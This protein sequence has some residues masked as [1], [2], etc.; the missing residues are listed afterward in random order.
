[1]AVKINLKRAEK[2]ILPDGDYLVTV[3]DCKEGESRSGNPKINVQMVVD[4]DA[5]PDFAGVKLYLD[6]S[7]QESAW[8]R[9]VELYE[10]AKG[11]PVPENEDGDFSFDPEDLIGDT[12]MAIVEIDESF[13]G[14]PR[15]K[16]VSVYNQEAVEEV[17]E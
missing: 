9:V 16:V 17:E 7:L 2:K 14:N 6:V 1:M 8:Y 5:H 10:A 13:D 15:N 12:M 3:V 4:E 11:T